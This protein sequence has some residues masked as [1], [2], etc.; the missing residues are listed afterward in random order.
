MTVVLQMEKGNLSIKLLKALQG[1]MLR[2][3]TS[4]TGVIG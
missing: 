3:S 2:D 1:L 4:S